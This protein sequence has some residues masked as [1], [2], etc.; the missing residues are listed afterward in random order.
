MRLSL[1]AGLIVSVLGIDLGRQGSTSPLCSG[2]PSV[3]KGQVDE[4][5]H[6]S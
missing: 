4:R 1:V 5:H 3:P 2:T 6:P